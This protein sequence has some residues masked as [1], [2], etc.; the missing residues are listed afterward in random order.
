LSANSAIK[1][2]EVPNDY[3]PVP[4]TPI[5]CTEGFPELVTVTEPDRLPTPLGIN[6]TLKVHCAWEA[7]VAP[8]GVAPPDA[9]ANSPFPTSVRFAVVARLLVTVTVCAALVVATVCP[10]KLSVVGANVSGKTALPLR[11]A[12]CCPIVA[13]SVT[14][15]EPSTFPLA[16]SA[17]ENV[18]LIAH[19]PLAFNSNPAAHGVA[20]LPPTEKSALGAIE[21]SVREAPLVFL[22]WTVFAALEVPATKDPKAAVA[23]LKVS[24]DVPP[25]LPVP[26]SPTN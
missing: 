9:A 13:V 22:I 14:V 7:S 4:E 8:Q 5:N 10:A 26:V 15:I 1:A 23:G 6:V 17:G 21:F 18:T 25:P 24:G 20:P 12:A 2:F 16:P 11:F 19:V 3:C